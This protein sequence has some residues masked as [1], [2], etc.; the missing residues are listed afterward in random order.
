[1][2]KT[3]PRRVKKKHV[4]K[5]SA[6]M[7]DDDDDDNVDES[8]PATGFLERLREELAP[9]RDIV[10]GLQASQQSTERQLEALGQ[11]IAVLEGRSPSL[12]SFP[13]LPPASSRPRSA[14][15]RRPTFE[16]RTRSASLPESVAK[17]HEHVVVVNGLPPDAEL[18][19]VQ[20]FMAKY[21]WKKSG[22]EYRLAMPRYAGR[23]ILYFTHAHLARE[24]LLR[25]REAAVYWNDSVRLYAAFQPT[26]ARAKDEY[27][28]RK[29]GAW[30]QEKGEPLDRHRPSL[31]HY[32]QRRLL[33]RISNGELLQ[34]PAW[35]A[36][37]SVGL[38]L[39]MVA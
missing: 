3:S 31:S 15:P 23:I 32:R 30:I 2:T 24:W 9:L 8:D 34:G 18:E 17:F 16:P 6:S 25:W 7:A 10:T 33:C 13:S 37:W 27:L 20:S 39:D 1:M 29:F 12:S 36:E 21:G 4:S 5:G 14:E 11:R 22:G 28:W 38:V 26:A 35:P 19:Q